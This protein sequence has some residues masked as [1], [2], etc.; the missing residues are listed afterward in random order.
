ME[1]K[2][3]GQW[4][5]CG[6]IPHGI[7]V[8]D[9][10]LAAEA[11]A[12][13]VVKS[14]NL[15]HPD[16]HLYKVDAK[17]QWHPIESI[18]NLTHEVSL[19][20]YSAAY[21]VCL[22]YDAERMQPAAANALLKTLEEPDD[23]T[24]ILLLTHHPQKILP[25]LLSRVQTVVYQ[26]KRAGFAHPGLVAEAFKGQKKAY[27]ELEVLL[28]SSQ[29]SPSCFLQLLMELMRDVFIRRTL[30]SGVPCLHPQE[31]TDRIPYVPLAQ[32]EKKLQKA[33]M[34]FERSVKTQAILT[35]LF[36]SSL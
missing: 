31:L 27:E 10:Q 20:R 5:E 36:S 8:V 3:L 16:I 33:Q 19:S 6:K 34:A 21:K 1:N 30:G 11:F 35:Y 15:E 22:V 28:D 23:N 12:M 18:R 7:L 9:G 14:K 24:L 26:E 17:T 4:L 29:D 25:T 32:W 2:Q 13:Q